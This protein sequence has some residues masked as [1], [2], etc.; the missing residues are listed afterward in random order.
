MYFTC[1]LTYSHMQFNHFLRIF[2]SYK[3]SFKN[4]QFFQRNDELYLSFNSSI[5][6]KF[7][8]N[9]DVIVYAKISLIVLFPRSK[10][11]FPWLSFMFLFALADINAR[12]ISVLWF[13]AAMCKAVMPS[14]SLALMLKVFHNLILIIRACYMQW[15]LARFIFC[16]YICRSFFNKKFDNW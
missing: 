4:N 6:L 13:K 1:F 15:H 14:L 8:L 11:V 9:D 7:K 12:T 2:K 5:I 16:F 3:F 10:G